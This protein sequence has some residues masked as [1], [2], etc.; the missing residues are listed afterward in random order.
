MSEELKP[1][2]FCGRGAVGIRFPKVMKSEPHRYEGY[3]MIC[4][5]SSS[6]DFEESTAVTHWN[7]RPIEDALKAELAKLRTENADLL[8]QLG[9]YDAIRAKQVRYE[10]YF[11]DDPDM[12]KLSECLKGC[13]SDIK[14]QYPTHAWGLALTI[15]NIEAMIIDRAELARKDEEIAALKAAWFPE[16]DTAYLKSLAADGSECLFGGQVPFN[17]CPNFMKN[18][19]EF[20]R[21]RLAEV[22]RG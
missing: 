11:N 5:G 9:E 17:K 13:I 3:C 22:S 15:E 19:Q 8:R 14:E 16:I 10:M 6:L 2:P 7:T 18:L 21:A 12:P 1:C 4:N 20:E